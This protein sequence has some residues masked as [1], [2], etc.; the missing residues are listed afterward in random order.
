MHVY[1][2]GSQK[3]LSVTAFSFWGTRNQNA[4]PKG[5]SPMARWNCS[6]WRADWDLSLLCIPDRK[7]RRGSVIKTNNSIKQFSSIEKRTLQILYSK[8]TFSF[9]LKFHPGRR[10]NEQWVLMHW[11]IGFSATIN[12]DCLKQTGMDSVSAQTSSCWKMQ[13]LICFY[14][15]E[16]VLCPSLFWST[17]MPE[18]S[19]LNARTLNSSCLIVCMWTILWN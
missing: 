4:I 7:H 12:D 3:S 19:I 15:S 16:S 8:R 11:F 10:H 17:S 18:K 14:L 13:A 1:C 9:L 2:H 5:W 6:I